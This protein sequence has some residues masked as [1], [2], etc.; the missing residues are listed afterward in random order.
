MPSPPAPTP[1]ENL[2]TAVSWAT[3]TS[4]K[5]VLTSGSSGGDNSP[6]KTSLGNKVDLY[7]V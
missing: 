5:L 3:S 1:H 4:Y 2:I 7:L 6:V